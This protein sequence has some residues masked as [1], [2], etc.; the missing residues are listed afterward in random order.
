MQATESI[1][2]VGALAAAL[3][4]GAVIAVAG[5]GAASAAPDGGANPAA[6]SADPSPA[7]AAGRPQK[8]ARTTA[9]STPRPAPAGGHAARGAASRPGRS[10]AAT[11][12]PADS[13][14]ASATPRAAARAATRDPI[15]TLLANATPA[16]NPVTV[17]QGPAGV[18]TGDLNVDDPDGDTVSFR[19]DRD[20][21]R[22]SV[23][24]DPAGRFIY[25]PDPALAHYGYAD[26]FVVTVSDADAGFHLHGLMGLLNLLT[27]GLIGTSGHVSTSTV[28]LTVAPVNNA[29]TATLVLGGP[30][31]AS[32]AVTGRID[33]VDPDADPV[34]FTAGTAA[35]G[36]VTLTADG[37]F[38]Y[39]PTATARHRAAALDAAAEERADSFTVTL[40]DGLGGTVEVPVTV[41]IDPFN[42]APATSATAGAP[43]PNGLVAG[44]VLGVDADGDALSYSGSGATAKGAVEVSADGSFSY[45][46]TAAARHGAASLTAG[47]GD[48]TDT[49]VVTVA[50]GHGAVVT[51]PITV[52]ISPANTGP[53]ATA[54]A[55]P[56]DPGAGVVTGAVAAT[57]ADG[58]RLTFAAS[59]PGKGAVVVAA[60]GSF[61]YTP[62]ASARHAAADLT[63][64]VADRFDA[65]TVT[66]SDGHGGSIVVPVVVAIAP[67]N[68]APTASA[69]VG[70]PDAAGVVAGAVLGADADGD[71][72]TYS[73]PSATAHGTV[74][75]AADGTFRYT[76]TAEARHLAAAGSLST[77]VVTVTVA[78]G[79]GGAV[80][81]A[82]SV[83]VAPENNAPV[84]TATAG[85]PDASGT[86][87]GR[88]RATDA[89]GDPLTYSV[90][91]AGKGIVA[92]A[93]DGSFTYIPTATARHNAAAIGA[94]AS[95]KTDSFTVTVSDGHGGSVSVPVTVAVSPANVVPSTSLLVGTPSATTGLLAGAV[96][97][98]DADGDLLRY[99]ASA[100]GKGTVTLNADG[101]FTYSPTALAR[102]RAGLADASPGDTVDA[103]T[104][105]VTDGH[106]GRVDVPV[107]VTVAPSAVSFAFAY[108]SGSAY[109]TAGARSALQSAADTIS[110]AIM[111]D[112]PV[113]VTFTMIGQN[114]PKSGV[115]A[116]TFAYYASGSPGYYGTVLQQKVITGVDANGSTVE[117]TI[118]W[119]FGYPWETGDSVSGS[120]Y[121]FQAVAL[122]ELLH[123]FGILSGLEGTSGMDRNWTTFDSYLT[124][125]T[126]TAV[127]GADYVWNP[128]Y[129][130]N[131]TGSGGGLYFAGPN[132]VAVYGAA[133]PLY[134]P[135]TWVSGTSLVHLDPSMSGSGTHVMNPY[136]YYG[137]GPRT[138]SPLELAMLTDLGY[139][140]A[141]NGYAVVI[142]GWWFLRRRRR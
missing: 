99:T 115:L 112:Q 37:S 16:L 125:S 65:F 87:T 25:T 13:D 78:D 63:A 35:R 32:G 18:L 82:V 73:G 27:F 98:V 139:T 129:T 61:T 120:E 38:T 70:S 21:A 122:H 9:A 14:P 132:A 118:T 39:T 142:V 12:V 90:S 44:A 34:T 4:V 19:I 33:A 85:S 94:P 17:A 97:G 138:I 83:A 59:T 71:P 28:N 7:R 100:A 127:I 116:N 93:A 88:V 57:D 105:T 29:P 110:A 103:F 22:G 86:V 50:D 46:P 62:T 10:A 55:A 141:P 66:V 36:A 134:T 60:D 123:A 124:T 117:S 45:T 30:D 133:V 5:S 56:P 8:A 42:T 111:V 108:G 26:S 131:L 41:T 79:H 49:V 130:P 137:P 11:S 101:S 126:G 23:S 136:E 96:L 102:H 15:S 95:A 104:V 77:D 6:G 113:T 107:T 114:V 53:A 51:V 74:V 80:N 121:D 24:V 119:N 109:W 135:S 2:R 52:M 91:T 47:P 68:T 3:G 1:G 76:P 40:D 20:P 64:A 31:P 67:S 81:L 140:I 48:T 58:D 54:T 128:A 106:G 69:T 75:I 72:L 92:V 84:A 89:D 43:D